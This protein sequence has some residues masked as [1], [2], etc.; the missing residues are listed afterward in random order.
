M[1]WTPVISEHSV[2]EFRIGG[3]ESALPLLGALLRY[4]RGDLLCPSAVM[5][6][7]IDAINRWGVIPYYLVEL[8][9]G[10]FCGGSD[11]RSETGIA[12]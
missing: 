1:F 8:S 4:W 10:M 7:A 6:D 9:T 2:R 3:L 12:G 11:L 5:R